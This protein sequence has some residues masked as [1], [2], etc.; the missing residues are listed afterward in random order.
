MGSHSP[1][2]RAPTLLD[3][4]NPI[5]SKVGVAMKPG[6]FFRVMIAGVGVV[7][8][9][10][11]MG[12]RQY[13][14]KSSGPNLKVASVVNGGSNVR[15]AS[16]ARNTNL[17][18][19]A[20]MSP[21]VREQLRN[22]RVRDARQTKDDVL[23]AMFSE[24]GISYPAAEVYVR[25][26]KLERDLEVWVRSQDSDKFQ[27]LVTYPICAMAGQVGPKRY[28]GDEQVP[29]G[30]YNIDLFNPNSA[31]HLSLRLNYPNRRDRAANVSGKPL[32]GDIFIHGGCKSIGCL[33][34]T[35]SGIRELYWLAVSARGFGQEQI[36]VHI[37]PTRMKDVKD[38]R[39][40][41][42]LKSFDPTLHAFWQELKPGYDYFEKT[43]QVPDVTVD[44]RGRYAVAT[45]TQ[46]SGKRA[47]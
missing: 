19:S 2:E 21:F 32:G 27:L 43:H 26:F 31:Y 3:P 42:R 28:Q 47:D 45:P 11:S 18:A 17:K 20:L 5:T 10:C 23:M 40:V 6:F 39:K 29:E 1:G 22:P 13:F 25:V 38:I 8:S 24:R 33:A 35:D 15:A 44:A 12:N 14:E 16:L 30:F 9:S 37:F 7:L 41:A 36:P 46:E 34:I 4:H